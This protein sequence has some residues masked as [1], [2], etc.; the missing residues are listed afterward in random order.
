VVA[1]LLLT[2]LLLWQTARWVEGFALDKTYRANLHTLDLIVENLR[3][4]L[5]RFRA[6]PRLL[7]TNPKFRDLLRTPPAPGSLRAANLAL[8]RIN[9]ITGAL[10]I[11][12]MDR[13]GLT[14]ASSNWQS[15]RPFVGRNFSYRPYFRQAMQGG[16]GR[17]FALGTTSKERGYYFAYPIRRKDEILGAIVVKIRVGHF[18]AGWVAKDHEIIVA[19][20]DGVIFLSSA[21]AWKFRTLEPLSD[22]A[23]ARIRASRQYGDATLE[24]LA[25]SDRRDVPGRGEILRIAGP[26]RDGEDRAGRKGIEYLVQQARMP[27]AG[28]RV[29]I[30]ARTAPIARQV[31]AAVM[32]ALFLVAGAL[33]IAAYVFERRRRIQERIVLQ[34]KAR[35]T[36]ERRVHER[37]RDLA[38]ANES[39]RKEIAEHRRTE[40]D[41]QRTQ[42]ELIQASRLATLGQVSAGL[43]HELNQPLAAIRSYADNARAFLDRDMPA[44]AQSNLADIAELTDRLA[45][46]IRHLKTYARKDPIAARPTPVVAALRESLSLLENRIRTEKVTVEAEL[47]DEDITVVGGDVRL[48]QVFVN[49]I[50]NA[51][52]AVRGRAGA[53]VSIGLGRDADDVV[54]TIRDNGPGIDE[55]D[56]PRVFDPFF[57]TKEVGQGL[58]LGLSIVYGLVKQ[59]GGA[60]EAANDPRGGATFSVRLK[61]ARAPGGETT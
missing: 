53:R 29:M 60:I 18:E 35:E 20:D 48:Q 54:V 21:P 10:D 47:P 25:V 34:Q 6:L 3:G 26:L 57:T 31:T 51:L 42:L 36:L 13:T 50:A 52:D 4:E 30:L 2:P 49:L 55:E 37:T 22:A 44:K 5:A 28:W 38:E 14:I 41:L 59:F 43:S 58:G 24:P 33:L 19:D 61:P 27:E 40:R 56:I 1:V 7:A 17:Y 45:R 11:Y 12:I 9:A 8:E 15:T 23:V 39:L 46:I 32:V 16:L